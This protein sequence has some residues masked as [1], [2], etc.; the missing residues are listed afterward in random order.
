MVEKSEIPIE[1]D[2]GVTLTLAL[3][4][5]SSYVAGNI[6]TI[7]E[8]YI[9]TNIK[10]KLDAYYRLAIDKWNVSLPRKDAA[11]N[12]MEK[13]FEQLQ[14][15]ILHPAAGKHPEEKEL[16]RLWAE[17]VLTDADCCTFIMYNQQ[18][19]FYNQEFEALTIAQNLLSE[20]LAD[21]KEAFL[22]IDEDLDRLLKRGSETGLS[23][24]QR[25]S[26][27][28][29]ITLPYS[30][31]LAGREVE[32]LKV[33]S[34]IHT[35]SALFIE[36]DSQQEA[37][38][39]A[40]ASILSSD[41]EFAAQRTI[42]VTN[43]DLFKEIEK[44]RNDYI[45]ITPLSENPWVA[46]Q[47]G[48]SVIRC[49][50]KAERGVMDGKIVLGM[51]DREQFIQS[52]KQAG[53]NDD[54]ARRLAIDVSLDIN[55]LWRNLKI[56]T[57]NLTWADEHHVRSLIPAMLVGKWDESC[58]NDKEL[59]AMLYGGSYEEYFYKLQ[60]II[61]AEESPLLKIGS[62][63]VVKAPYTIYN[64][65]YKDI[66][67]QDL[68]RYVECLDWLL[69]DDDP[70]VLAK[71][72]KQQLRLWQNRRAYSSYI[73]E[74]MLQSLAL[75][76]LVFERNNRKCDIIHKSIQKQLAEFTQERY[77]SNMHNMK[78]I[79]EADPAAFLHFVHADILHEAK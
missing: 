76:S 12:N 33:L 31:I 14:D 41:D 21:Q 10:E 53:L 44:E 19:L 70:D 16:L 25:K 18:A 65:F 38:A 69:E 63:W 34:I 79:A 37:M 50:S 74:G 32:R 40:A 2:M 6:P 75:L 60:F 59:I 57:S 5:I 77:F 43:A 22:K 72:E 30:T 17:Y 68:N 23:F 55:F 49:M 67:N 48:H 11:R 47:N 71:I 9:G 29:N 62:T 58:K 78:W 28:D 51:L 24:W 4:A 46:V 52:L 61:N 20:I 7:R 39:F 35:P 73:R 13:H 64:I 56:E 27:A 1:N 54:Y 26:H 42:V 15:Y 3:G 36:A 45:I 66:T 8:L